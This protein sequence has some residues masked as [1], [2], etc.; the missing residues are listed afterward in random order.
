MAAKQVLAHALAAVLGIGAATA[1]AQNT[2]PNRPVR[3]IV[4]ASTGSGMDYMGRSVAL[5]LSEKYRQQVI[6]D[7]RAGAGSLIGTN[8]VATATPDAYTLGVASTSSL[9][10][11]LLQSKPPY[12]PIDDLAPIALLS[13]LVSIMVVAPGVQAKNVQE[14]VALAKARPGQFNFASIGAGSA[15]HLT[16]EIFNRAA[17]IQAVHVPF[18][19][20]PDIISEMLASRVH[21]L[22]FISPASLPMVR[23]GKLR[24][25][26]VTGSKRFSGLPDVPTMAEAG[27][28]GADVDTMI[29]LVGPVKLPRAMIQRI[30]ADFQEVMARPDVKTAFER[31]G[32]EPALGVTTA[33]YAERW[34]AEY[35]VYRKLLPEIGLK[36]Q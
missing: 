16:P 32:G 14:F 21:Y 26:A 7:N 33:A 10:A 5:A 22:I 31:Q 23:D 17:G 19:T 12:H 18:K 36:P 6:I 15:A 8:I 9:V 20:V 24:P 1:Q 29:G 13:S 2:Y 27:V 28:K 11:P 35:E 34:K 3:V 30:H 25:F 4:P